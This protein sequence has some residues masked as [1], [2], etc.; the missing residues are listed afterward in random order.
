MPAHGIW[1]TPQAAQQR[2]GSK[3]LTRDDLIS[4]EGRQ[5][6]YREAKPTSRQND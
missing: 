3:T 6:I 5:I 4:G 2:E 1:Q